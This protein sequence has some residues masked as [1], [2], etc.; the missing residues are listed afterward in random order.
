VRRYQQGNKV[1]ARRM[2]ADMNV[3]E[4]PAGSVGTV[5]ATTVLGKPKKVHFALKRRGDP[6]S[7]TSTFAAATSI[8][9]ERVRQR[10]TARACAHAYWS[11]TDGRRKGT[12]GRPTCPCC[13]VG[14]ANASR[15]SWCFGSHHS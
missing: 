11:T 7:F 4:V 12:A 6:N 5:V 3:P 14:T 9:P 1:T 15:N 13:S 2:I 10:R 8:N